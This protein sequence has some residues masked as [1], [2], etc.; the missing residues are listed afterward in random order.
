LD[1]NFGQSGSGNSWPPPPSTQTGVWPPPPTFQP[2][3]IWFTFKT[4][5]LRVE[6][7]VPDFRLGTINLSD[8]GFSIQGKAVTRYE[9]QVP[10]LIAC[11]LLRFGFLIAYAILEYA[12]RRDV[13]LSVP[14]A[15]VR[16]VVLVPS[17]QRVCLVYDAPNY[18]GVLKTFS[19]VF[20]PDPG[21][22]Q[23]FAATAQQFIPG[24]V[25]EGRLRTWTSPASWI[26]MGGLILGL[27]IL[28]I[29]V[30]AAG[31]NSAS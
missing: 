8:V 12:V 20:K 22:Y 24:R 1:N 17:K 2:Q 4:L 7:S 28:L 29:I 9:I 16:Q 25:S 19:L 18:K 30:A 5:F 31:H 3:G 11:L 15:Q 21:Q 26:F 23:N 13:M 6:G 27:I 10:I 14:W